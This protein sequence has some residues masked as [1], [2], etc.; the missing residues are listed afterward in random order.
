MAKNRF[1][2]IDALRGL[3]AIAVVL[4]HSVEQ[5]LALGRG[6][7]NWLLA[8]LRIAFLH[9]A[10]F[11]K[12][13]VVTF[14]AISGFVIPFSFSAGESALRKFAI[15]RFFRLYPAYWLSIGL[16]L[17]IVPVSM[18]QLAANLTMV[19]MAFRQPDILGVYWTLFI[20]IVFYVLCACAFAA[21]LLKSTRY[22]LGAGL[23]FLAASVG[24]AYIRWRTGSNLPVALPLGLTVMHI[25]ALM[26]T[27]NR[28]AQ[29]ALIGALTLSSPLICFL[30]YQHNQS[31]GSPLSY[32]VSYAIGVAVFLVC[33]E[34][35]L[36]VSRATLYLGAASYSLYLFH[37]IVLIVAKELCERLTWPL[38]GF[39]LPV[40]VVGV[41]VP[42]AHAVYTYLEAP[43]ISFGR[44]L[45][46][47]MP[48]K[49]VEVQ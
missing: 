43:A 47:L 22:L 6:H 26:R 14:F 12:V 39:L 7:E 18:R 32:F 21:G 37:P 28:S 3:A 5:V 36:F 19:Q 1:D 8:A 45:A 4:Q 34:K 49:P 24:M 13:G 9:W 38:S 17:L 27:D 48:A 2:N 40:I 35:K 25:G 46:S 20:E 23:F 33:V 31:D 41:S 10:N 29:I 44:R 30:A 16:A 42:L 11:G 15:S